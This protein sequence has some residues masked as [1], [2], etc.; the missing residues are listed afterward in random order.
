MQN[1]KMSASEYLRCAPKYT[2]SRLN[3]QNFSGEGAQPLPRPSPAAAPYPLGTFGASLLAPS[4]L[5][6]HSKFL[7]TPLMNTLCYRSVAIPRM[8]IMISVPLYTHRPAKFNLMQAI[9]GVQMWWSGA[10]VSRWASARFLKIQSRFHIM[11]I[12]VVLIS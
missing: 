10:T 5:V 8:G 7:A 11:L 3:N 2:I 9:A 4:T 12:A 1:F 6:P